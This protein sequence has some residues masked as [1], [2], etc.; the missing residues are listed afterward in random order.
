MDR[1]VVILLA[2]SLRHT[3]GGGYALD[4][5]C[6]KYH[7]HLPNQPV[8]SSR[9]PWQLPLGFAGPDSRDQFRFTW[10]NT[11]VGDAVWIEHRGRW[12]AGVVIGRG[13]EFVQVAAAGTGKRQPRVR[14]LYC[15]L[16]RR[17]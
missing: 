6:Q 13:H 4:P 11:Q 16:R 3:S 2:P 9:E 17:R 14:K 7:N 5:Q 8:K 10:W 12:L 1:R 15:E